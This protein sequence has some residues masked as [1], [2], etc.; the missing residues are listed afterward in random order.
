VDGD[1]V[2][3]CVCEAEIEGLADG[4][5]PVEMDDVDDGLSVA[6]ADDVA[7]TTNDVLK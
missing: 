4:D 7:A 1:V 3:D 2:A 5:A 6:V